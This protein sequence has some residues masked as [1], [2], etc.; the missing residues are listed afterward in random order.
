VTYIVV[1]T[2]VASA[3]VRGPVPARLAAQLT[4]NTICVSFVTVGELVKWTEMRSWRPSKLAHLGMWLD[5][6][7][8]LEYDVTVATTW[9]QLQAR[10]QRRGRPRPVN[11]SWIAACCLVDALPL[12]N[13]Y[14]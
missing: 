3:A 2:D 9:G 10:A 7:V 14:V 6:A 11:D 5:R 13:W 1:D 12:A 4:T 8:V